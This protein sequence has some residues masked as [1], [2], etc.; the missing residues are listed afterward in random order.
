MAGTVWVAAG[1]L[2][3][4]ADLGHALLTKLHVGWSLDS[5]HVIEVG[6]AFVAKQFLG[7]HRNVFES[8]MSVGVTALANFI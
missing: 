8:G 6:Q 5:D 7:D 2:C 1:F 3:H 4:A